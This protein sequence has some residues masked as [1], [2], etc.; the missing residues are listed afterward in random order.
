MPNSSKPKG[1]ESLAAAVAADVDRERGSRICVDAD[2]RRC[3]EAL[4]A[5]EP[6]GALPCGK[7]C[8]ECGKLVWAVERAAKTAEVFGL[9]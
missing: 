8:E 2:A 5:Y 4:A 7:S 3:E 6:G 1:V 9:D